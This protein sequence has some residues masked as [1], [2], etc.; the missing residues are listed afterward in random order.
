[1]LAGENVE[2]ML[3]RAEASL[4]NESRIEDEQPY[5]LRPHSPEV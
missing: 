3:R 1:M 5:I 2:Q 4:I